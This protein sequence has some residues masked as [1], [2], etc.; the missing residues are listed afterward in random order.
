MGNGTGPP[1]GEQPP[2]GFEWLPGPTP[3]F[4][5]PS[6]DES[7]RPYRAWIAQRWARLLRRKP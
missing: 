1:P 5:D 7:W 2:N 4:D 6:D 3:P